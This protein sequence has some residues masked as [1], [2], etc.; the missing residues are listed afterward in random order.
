M[1][2]S[3]LPQ[4]RHGDGAR[5]MDQ[6]GISNALGVLSIVTWLGAQSPQIYENYRNKSVEG[7]ALP[8][9]ISWFAGDFTNFLGCVL[10]HQLPFQTFLAGYFILVDVILCGQFYYYSRTTLP[11]LSEDFPYAQPPSHITATHPHLAHRRSRSR[12]RRSRSSRGKETPPYTP[13]AEDDL[14]QRSWMSESSMPSTATT[15]PQFSQRPL[16]SRNNSHE[17]ATPTPPTAPSTIPP[18]PTVPE[19]GRTLTRASHFRT[20]DPSL[21]TIHGSPSTNGA[22]MHPSLHLNGSSSH[23]SFDPHPEELY[24]EG[25]GLEVER[26]RR[27]RTSSSRSRPPPPSRRSTSVVFLSVGALVTFGNAA[28]GGGGVGTMR[29]NSGGAWSTDTL[30]TSVE[31]P[32]H[33]RFSRL[34]HPAFFA[35]SSSP[36]SSPPPFLLDRVLPPRRKRSAIPIDYADVEASFASAPPSLDDDEPPS[37]VGPD[38]ERI[39]GRTSAWL[40]TT[41]YLTSRLPQLWQNFRRRSVEGLA[42]TLFVFA[43][44][45]NSLYV[46]SILTNPSAS[47]VPGY[48]LESTPYLLGSGGTLCFDLMILAQSVLYSPRRKARRDRDRRRRQAHGVEAEEEAALLQTDEGEDADEEGTVRGGSRRHSRSAHSRSTSAGT[49]FSARSVSNGRRSANGARPPSARRSDST[50]MNAHAPGRTGSRAERGV[51]ADEPF[52]FRFGE[53]GEG[54]EAG[55]GGSRS[56]SRMRTTSSGAA[57][58]AAD[59]PESIP[60]AGESSVTVKGV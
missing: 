56:R 32:A 47:S 44:I 20:F 43:F 22:F 49:A 21:S 60:E 36:S 45:G 14:M 26:Q 8:F 23:V 59:V 52:D 2:A 17:P 30:S 33:P 53:D 42:M 51:L 18:S 4:A 46:A 3:G 24:S 10:T 25:E 5:R 13:A 55:Q 57:S 40:C 15:S 50:E 35:Y 29:A 27:Q 48:L 54:G 58:A 6:Q 31:A 9:L 37:P 19:R 39:I 1:T 16:H 34:Q 12:K 28:W 41:F 11:P 7:L 38:W